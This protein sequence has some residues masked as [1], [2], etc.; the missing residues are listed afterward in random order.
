MEGDLSCCRLPAQAPG[1]A[2]ALTPAPACAPAPPPQMRGRAL[3]T[4]AETLPP[5]A[6]TPA[7]LEL[8]W[9]VV[10]AAQ[11]GGWKHSAGGMSS[12]SRV[13]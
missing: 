10:S 5:K 13:E 2:L 9:L 11:R 4:L 8:Q 12:T 6:D 7:P 1:R 3:R